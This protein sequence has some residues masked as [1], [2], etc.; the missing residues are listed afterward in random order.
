[1]FCTNCGSKLSDDAR[2]CTNCGAAVSAVP[3]VQAPSAEP[4]PAEQ[5]PVAE[6]PAVD[7]PAADTPA[8]DTP[9]EE[10]AYF[11]APTEVLSNYPGPVYQQPQQPQPPQ[12]PAYVPPVQPAPAYYS[13]APAAPKKKKKKTGLIIGIILLVLVLAAAGVAGFLY[14]QD[15]Q[16]KNTAYEEAVAMLESKDYDGAL[17]AFQALEDYK[18]SAD[19]AQELTELQEQYDAAMAL[20]NSHQFEEAGKAFR[21]L[22]EYRDSAEYTDTEI[23]YL[24]ATYFKDSAAAADTEA[25]YI[26]KEQ[27][28]AEDAAFA[29]GQVTCDL[30]EAAAALYTELADYKDSA[31]LA[32]ECWLG[33]ALVWM[34][35]WEDHDAALGYLDK[36]NE[37]DAAT[38]NA[39]YQDICVDDD[40]LAAVEEALTVWYD[41]DDIYNAE[42]E[43]KAAIDILEVYT[44]GVFDS[45]ALKNM[46]TELLSDLNAIYLQVDGDDIPDLLSYYDACIGFL[47]TTATLCEDFGVFTTNVDMYT[48]FTETQWTVVAYSAIERSLQNWYDNVSSIDYDENEGSYYVQYHNS[49]D[50]AFT[51]YIR[52]TFEDESYNVLGQSSVLSVQVQAGAEA[53]IYT[54]DLPDGTAFLDWDWAYELID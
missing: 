39:R 42:E 31:D 43:I 5:A 47:D 35:V 15:Q 44:Y 18:D 19:Q 30:Y 16:K 45:Q 36:L 41:A 46:H 48:Y 4:E 33:A 13:D 28:A 21:K 27:E 49:T 24:K 2:F 37:E 29:E 17:T 23:T 50:Y 6:T 34:D 54:G 7:T 8:A 40:V 26:M 3:P 22:K 53:V 20:L 25:W 51:L 12:Q 10:S 32:S 1:M 52:F 11:D 9:V 14:L 38:L